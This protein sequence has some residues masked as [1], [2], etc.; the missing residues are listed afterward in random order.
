MSD[1]SNVFLFPGRSP[2]G[3]LRDRV[4]G[5]ARLDKSDPPVMAANL[6]K[7]AARLD[8]A[9]PKDAAR[10]MFVKA[11]GK[12][13]EAVWRK[14]KRLIRLPG[15]AAG[16]FADEGDY[17][18]GGAKYVRLAES[19]AAM[20]AE[21]SQREQEA[22]I[23]SLMRGTTLDPI[24]SRDLG[25][26]DGR[27]HAVDVL[28]GI[29]LKAQAAKTC[30]RAFEIL[31]AHPIEPTEDGM[32]YFESDAVGLP[33]DYLSDWVSMTDS[34]LHWAI[35]R[36]ELG[37]AYFPVSMAC[38][39]LGSVEAL[40]ASIS[41]DEQAAALKE[42]EDSFPEWT[43][44]QRQSVALEDATMN[45]ARRILRG[46]L[47]EAEQADAP[48]R[49][50]NARNGY[51]APNA[52]DDL[53][54]LQTFAR[55]RV[56]LCLWPDLNGGPPDVRFIVGSEEGWFGAECVLDV[57]GNYVEVEGE[58]R[59][60]DD[61]STDDYLSISLLSIDGSAYAVP[62]MEARLNMRWDWEGVHPLDSD[63]VRD[64]LHVDGHSA[65][66]APAVWDDRSKFVPAPQAT[67]A[68]TILRNMAFAAD[69]DRLEQLLLADAEERLKPVVDFYD[70]QRRAFE[71]AMDR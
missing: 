24:Q 22:A 58:A 14:R 18:S 53:R 63:E 60:G 41:T 37:F 70:D 21:G 28:K 4:L 51:S 34:N 26:I 20:K 25:D 59:L 64:L 61:D 42:A 65:R 3:A 49:T 9:R 56:Q 29:A 48:F 50:S 12:D 66:F 27:E 57:R 68:S 23:R 33:D 39:G 19:F 43:D 17:E 62:S 11:F 38:Y 10:K 1:S 6:G 32:R 40:M 71:E 46:K 55:Y 5:T 35:P 31:R 30:A 36:I 13:S 44:A 2:A 67:L 7:M 45:C 16:A 15:E 52:T 47:A 8:G 54:H 69:G